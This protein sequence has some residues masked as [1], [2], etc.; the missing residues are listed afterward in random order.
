MSLVSASLSCSALAAPMEP[1]RWAEQVAR[2]DGRDLVVPLLYTFQ[3][4]RVEE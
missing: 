3:M 4:T 1:L 2:M